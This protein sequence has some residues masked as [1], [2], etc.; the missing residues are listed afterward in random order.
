[1]GRKEKKRAVRNLISSSKPDLIF[2]QETKIAFVN[3]GLLNFLWSNRNDFK[4][5]WANAIGA[6]GGL[7]SMWSSDFF[8][9]DSSFVNQRYIYFKGTIKHIN[10]HCI[11]VNIYALNDAASRDSLWSEL[12]DMKL[13]SSVLWCIGVDFNISCYVSFVD[14]IN[15]MSLVDLLFYMD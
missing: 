9:L 4:G 7:I 5:E 13:S 8:T 11:V 14:F 3:I 1:M 6:S 2:L 15:A 12:I 10:L